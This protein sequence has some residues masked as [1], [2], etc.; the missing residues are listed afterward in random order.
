MAGLRIDVMR[1]P[2]LLDAE[3]GRKNQEY[4]MRNEEKIRATAGS[5]ILYSSSPAV[6]SRFS[7]GSNT[8]STRPPGIRHRGSSPILPGAARRPDTD[9]TW[10]I[11]R[12][13]FESHTTYHVRCTKYL[14]LL[15]VAQSR[16]GS[17]PLHC[18]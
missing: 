4:R 12:R 8:I 15:P 6:R 17:L 10:Y 14:I 13:T 1:R 7:V 16:S 9:G 11:V 3:G 5:A 2:V 18:S